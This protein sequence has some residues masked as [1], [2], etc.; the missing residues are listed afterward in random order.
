[1]E[2]MEHALA[3]D[4]RADSARA[5][6]RRRILPTLLALLM[7]WTLAPALTPA[8]AED[9]IPGFQ[10]V[11]NQKDYYYD[12]VYWAVDA[13][14]TTGT[15]D[16][17]FSPDAPCRR[18]QIVTFI[19][20]MC[21]EV[22]SAESAAY[23]DVRPE[24]YYSGAVGWAAEQ[25]ITT[26]TSDTTFSP[27]NPCT[28]AQIVTFLWRMD[29]QPAASSALKFSDV[30]TGAYYADAVKW[31][32]GEGIT[33][34]MTET[35]FA[36]DATCTR[37]QTV[38]FLQRY[39]NAAVKDNAIEIVDVD[40][41]PAEALTAVPDVLPADTETEVAFYAVA[42]DSGKDYTVRDEDGEVIAALNDKG[43][44]GDE[45]AGDSIF[46][47]KA[48]L[49]LAAE[50]EAIYSVYADDRKAGDCTIGTYTKK[51]YNQ[52]QEALRILSDYAGSQFDSINKEASGEELEQAYDKMA[53]GIRA[54]LKEMQNAGQIVSWEAADRDFTVQLPMGTCVIP[55]DQMK[56]EQDTWG[57][58]AEDSQPGQLS[59]KTASL[60][61][62]SE[63][64]SQIV[65]IETSYREAQNDCH[66]ES[67][68]L[69]EKNINGF[70]FSRE[71]NYDYPHD[72]YQIDGTLSGPLQAMNFFRDQLDAFNVIIWNGHGNYREST[73]AFLQSGIIKN[74]LIEKSYASDLASGRLLWSVNVN[75]TKYGITGRFFQHYYRDRGRRF[76]D[77]L[78]YLGSCYSGKDGGV[79]KTLLSC[80]A[81]VAIGYTD[82]VSKIYEANF[83]KDF[84]KKLVKKNW[85]THKSA[86]AANAFDNA[87]F[88]NKRLETLL[89]SGGLPA[90][91]VMYNAAGGEEYRLT[92]YAFHG[93]DG[94][95]DNENPAGIFDPDSV[96]V[97]DYITFGNYEQDNNSENGKEPIEWKVLDK[98]EGRILV[99]SRFGLDAMFY[100]KGLKNVTWE[101]CSLRNWLN[102]TFLEEAFTAYEESLIQTVTVSNPD[103]PLYG[104]EGGSDTLDQVF[105]L[106]LPEMQ[107]Y[108]NLSDEIVDYDGHKWNTSVHDTFIG[109]SKEVITTPTAYALAQGVLTYSYYHD[110]DGKE[111][112][113]CWL[114]SPGKDSESAAGVGYF[115]GVDAEGCLVKSGYKSAVRPAMWINIGEGS[116]SNLNI[117]AYPSNQ[118]LVLCQ[119]LAQI[120]MR[121]FSL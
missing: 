56:N 24:D 90:E 46:T 32:V 20:R 60:M 121:K 53:A 98:K 42:K 91:P 111:S 35:I 103:N 57:A 17:T 41:E 16:T 30:K 81:K 78:V 99:L 113:W 114:R 52:S 10:D 58:A 69:I 7:I 102:S 14:I 83:T 104:T 28:R 31:A 29:G 67:A 61:A 120:K 26:G 49:T 23:E 9:S 94:N 85:F 68:Q 4:E 51:A 47:G 115:G 3:A 37:A 77:S 110:A 44:D 76:N 80:G 48:A 8:S 93:P 43:R 71:V 116:N 100:N 13:G 36:P 73:G 88:L 18:A 119:D 34:G 21:G 22:N 59:V 74:D 15:S 107:T 45:N 2:S 50:Q 109:F 33:T 62:D 95:G 12:P 92:D 96:S 87:V 25:G 5:T 19:W 118:E 63:K 108:Y 54:K 55:L 105:L 66:D 75:G 72:Y 117:A 82:A 6:V 65:S 38:T 112:C 1:M 64:A 11:Q 101:S 97:G 89:H 79:A 86:T 27:G 106:S 70:Q 40:P 84:F 39:F